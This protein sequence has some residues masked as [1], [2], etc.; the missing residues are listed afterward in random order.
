MARQRFSKGDRIV[1]RVGNGP[2]NPGTVLGYTDVPGYGRQLVVRW[3]DGLIGNTADDK[4][5]RPA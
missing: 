1:F 5:V 2:D 3:D 4:D